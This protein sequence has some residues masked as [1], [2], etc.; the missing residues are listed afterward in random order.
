MKPANRKENRKDRRYAIN[1]SGKRKVV[2]VMRERLGAYAAA[3]VTT[4]CL[5]PI[6]DPAQLPE[7]IDGLAPA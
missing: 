6:C 2:V 5:M 4:L 1:Q 7:L 3:G